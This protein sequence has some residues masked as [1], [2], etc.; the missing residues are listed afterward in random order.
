MGVQP[1]KKLMLLFSIFFLFFPKG[2]WFSWDSSS[3]SSRE[4]AVLGIFRY[5]SLSV[6]SCRTC[7]KAGDNPWSLVTAEVTHQRQQDTECQ[8]NLKSWLFY[9]SQEKDLFF[10][11]ISRSSRKRQQLE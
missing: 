9:S 2:F 8:A 1:E 10:Y 4:A 7:G 3:L 11:K 6:T 5:I